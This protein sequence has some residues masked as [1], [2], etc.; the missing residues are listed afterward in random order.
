MTIGSNMPRSKRQAL[1]EA[2]AEQNYGG[3][4]LLAPINFKAG[5]ED[6]FAEA[7]DDFTK[8]VKFEGFAN[9]GGPDLGDDIVEPSAFNNATLSEYLK[10]GRQLLFMHDR[11]AQVGEITSAKRVSKNTRSKFGIT[12][13]GLYVEGFVD[14][15][16]DSMGMIPDHPLAKVI[17]FARMQVQ[18]GR[19][20]LLSIGWRPV[21]TEIRKAPDP[22]RGNEQRSFRLIKSL[23]LGEVSLV[24]MAMSP[25]SMIELSKA[26]RGAY[27]D[28]ITDALFAE[29]LDAS[30]VETL[31]EPKT[32]DGFTIERVRELAL[33]AEVAARVAE[34]KGE[35]TDSED[36]NAGD[37]KSTGPRYK[38]VS[39]ETRVESDAAKRY[40]VVSLRKG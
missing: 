15:P 7:F 22:R 6:E 30:D 21:K 10:F 3:G 26:Y 12:E 17:H 9:V 1:R 39:L 28:E 27:G 40:N 11:Y 20:K 29:H 35:I 2:V 37:T 31:T 25:Q 4:T 24:T 19:L 14:S 16:L 13:G 23:I 34:A 33:R 8:P 36:D 5:A 38:L 32:S 18:K